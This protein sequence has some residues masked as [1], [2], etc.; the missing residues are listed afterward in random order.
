M[1]NKTRVLS[2]NSNICYIQN[3][4]SWDFFN[5]PGDMLAWLINQLTE[6]EKEGGYAIILAHVPNLDECTQQYAR[7]YH[8]I[9]DRFQHIIRFGMFSHVHAELIQVMRDVNHT[10]SINMNFIV[11]SATTFLGKPPMFDVIYLDP[12]TMLP[13]ELETYIFNLEY[14][15]RLDEPRY[16]LYIDYKKDYGLEDLSPASFMKMS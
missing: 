6:I 1:N 13:V 5:D 7:R 10:S 16:E 12:D 4:A 9:T 2:L 8:A 15:N 14:A 11:G 3:F